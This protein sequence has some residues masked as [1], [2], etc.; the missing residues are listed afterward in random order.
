M[1]V[2][3]Q[4]Q[5]LL[6]RGTAGEYTGEWMLVQLF[7]SVLRGQAGGLLDTHGGGPRSP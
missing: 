1:P 3:P 5:A 4:I 6:D 2:D 7:E